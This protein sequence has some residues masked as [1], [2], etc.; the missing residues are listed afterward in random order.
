M[1]LY[2]CYAGFAYYVNK[3]GYNLSKQGKN[4]LSLFQPPGKSHVFS[5]YVDKTL[6]DCGVVYTTHSDLEYIFYESPELL[7]IL[8]TICLKPILGQPECACS[9]CSIESSL[10]GKIATNISGEII[11]CLKSNNGG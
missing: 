6:P 5:V 2:L 9:H 3:Y 4:L 11:R 7:D 8:K 10:R 1:E